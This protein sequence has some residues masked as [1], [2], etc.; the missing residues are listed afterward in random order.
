M[1]RSW[2]KFLAKSVTKEKSSDTRFNYFKRAPAR[3]RCGER[4]FIIWACRNC[5]PARIP[6]AERHWNR[7]GLLGC[8]NPYWEK[9]KPRSVSCEGVKA[10]SRDQD[11]APFPATPLEGKVKSCPV[12]TVAGK[13]RTKKG[14]MWSGAFDSSVFFTLCYSYVT[15][16][17]LKI[18]L[19]NNLSRSLL[20][21][22]R[23]R[24]KTSMAQNPLYTL[25]W[26]WA[27]EGLL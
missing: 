11:Y 5:E 26:F 21:L 2:R 27:T 25:S 3:S 1:T 7:R 19:H 12:P 4:I 14:F 15:N 13:L 9:R 8:K 18:V 17:Q 23:R 22:V 24:S 10:R 6:K 20:C 16:D